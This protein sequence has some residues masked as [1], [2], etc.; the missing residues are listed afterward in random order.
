MKGNSLYDRTDDTFKP[1]VGKKVKCLDKDGKKR[2]GVLDFAGIN[3]KLHHK[4]QVTLDRTPIW[5]VDP[6]TIKLYED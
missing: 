4:F 1:F 6:K 3:D 2:V 5:P